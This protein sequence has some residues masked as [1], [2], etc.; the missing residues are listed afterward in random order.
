MGLQILDNCTFASSGSS[1]PDSLDSAQNCGSIALSAGKHLLRTVIFQG[2]KPASFVPTYRY[3]VLGFVRS[4]TPHSFRLQRPR[5][6]AP[7]ICCTISRWM[8]GSCLQIFARY[9]DRLASCFLHKAVERSSRRQRSNARVRWFPPTKRRVHSWPI[10]I[11]ELWIRS[12]WQSGTFMF[13]D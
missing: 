4:L 11:R 12:F 6:R 2:L 7:W 10:N 3:K 13:W 9:L 5:H 1:S 8:G